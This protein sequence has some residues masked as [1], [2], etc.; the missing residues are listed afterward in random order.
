MFDNLLFSPWEVFPPFDGFI[1][2]PFAFFENGVNLVKRDTF[3]FFISSKKK[4]HCFFR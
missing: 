2:R 4:N 1:V 3:Q